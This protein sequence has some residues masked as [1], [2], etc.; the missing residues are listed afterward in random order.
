MLLSFRTLGAAQ[1]IAQASTTSAPLVYNSIPQTAEKIYRHGFVHAV[2]LHERFLFKGN[3][4]RIQCH[5]LAKESLSVD[6]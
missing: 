6:G 4:Q 3:M 2:A 5:Q 1:A